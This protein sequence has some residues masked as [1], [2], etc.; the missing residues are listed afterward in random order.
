MSL[1]TLTFAFALTFIGQVSPARKLIRSARVGDL[2]VTV[3]G[4][5]LPQVPAYS[6]DR[7]HLLAVHVTVKNVSAR[8]SQSN[9]VGVSLT[10]KPYYEYP[11]HLDRATIEAVKPP[12]FLQLLPGEESTGG[13]VFEV[14]NGTTPLALI[15][16]SDKKLSI[17]LTGFVAESDPA[18]HLTCSGPNDTEIVDRNTRP[19]IPIYKPKPPYSDAAARA[20]YEG[21]ATLWITVD[22]QGDVIDPCVVT[23]LGLGLDEVAIYS[24]R[25]WKFM[26]A[27]RNG[28]ATQ[29]RILEKVDFRLR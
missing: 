24:V 27:I 15:L 26:P 22:A 23:P 14:R 16:S 17:D 6:S 7:F 25:T 12:N 1:D 3:T 21:T 28:V 10:V 11:Q 19:P 4:V 5:W 9:F 13:Y 29:V 20:K 2:L 8:I 18:S